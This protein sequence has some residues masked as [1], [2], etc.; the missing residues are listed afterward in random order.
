[1]AARTKPVSAATQKL[2]DDMNNDDTQR[3]TEDK[4]DKAKKLVRECRDLETANAEYAEKMKSNSER[5]NV[6]KTKELV[7]MFDEV[8]INHL[9]LDAEGNMPPYEIEIKP[10]Y[11]ANIKIED[12]PDAPKAFAY[13]RKQGEGDMIKTTYTVAFGMGEAKKQKAF[14]SLLKKAKVEYDAKF[15]VPWNT[16]TAWL[17]RQ[18]EVEKK[19]PPLQ[20][21]GAT[22][23]RRADVKKSKKKG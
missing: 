21:L 22:V 19:T 8:G 20:L 18:V 13:L 6:L 7:D 16:L 4:L 1:M 15:G 10:Y 12:N 11:H 9:G 3:P 14:E 17:K 23:G 5:I 2:L